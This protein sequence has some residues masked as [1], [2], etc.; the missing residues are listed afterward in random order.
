MF[1]HPLPLRYITLYVLLRK[2]PYSVC[3]LHSGRGWER[4]GETE[5]SNLT[6]IYMVKSADLSHGARLMGSSRMISMFLAGGIEFS[7]CV[8]L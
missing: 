4:P 1:C 6:D 2:I 3:E 7:R 5:V 8:K